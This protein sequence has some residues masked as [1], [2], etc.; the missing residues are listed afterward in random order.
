MDDHYVRRT[1]FLR[2]STARLLRFVRQLLVALMHK[3]DEM[4]AKA[5]AVRA[6]LTEDELDQAEALYHE[7][8]SAE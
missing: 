3:E 7:V 1:S 6:T 8:T 2:T 4:A 5:R